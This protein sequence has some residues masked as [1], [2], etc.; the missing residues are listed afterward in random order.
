MT[1][2]LTNGQTVEMTVD[3]LTDLLRSVGV[4]PSGLQAEA[5]AVACERAW[6]GPVKMRRVIEAIKP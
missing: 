2:V 6:P 3:E 4:T 5:W 1:V